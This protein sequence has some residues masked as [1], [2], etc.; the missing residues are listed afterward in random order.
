MGLFD[1]IKN[2]Q[3]RFLKKYPYERYELGGERI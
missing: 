2:S 1:S 3:F